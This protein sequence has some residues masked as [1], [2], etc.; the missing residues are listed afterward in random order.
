MF[1]Q[2]VLNSIE[3]VHGVG[4]PCGFACRDRTKDTVVSDV[5]GLS[6]EYDP[7]TH[8]TDDAIVVERAAG[9]PG[10]ACGAKVERQ[11]GRIQERH[12]PAR[13]QRTVGKRSCFQGDPYFSCTR[14]GG[15][16]GYHGR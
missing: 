7:W 3:Y 2:A 9:R 16:P 12:S 14:I 6:F 10:P 15:A 1:G 8:F 4:V 13:F 11:H 5:P